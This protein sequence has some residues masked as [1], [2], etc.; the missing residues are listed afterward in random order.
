DLNEKKVS[1]L[2]L[3]NLADSRAL[4]IIYNESK[5]NDEKLRQSSAF[6]LRFMESQKADL[7]LQ[8]IIKND[9][10]EIVKINA[11]LA[12][13][14]RKKNLE[15]LKL[16]KYILRNDNSELVR[17]EALKNLANLGEK[18]DVEFALKNDSSKSIRNFAK[19]LLANFN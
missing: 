16:Q 3:G 17:L 14:F 19:N 7:Y 10:S 12:I 8:E 13:S 1:I 11:L 2:S 9:E 18:E 4:E 5:S 6:A 15:N